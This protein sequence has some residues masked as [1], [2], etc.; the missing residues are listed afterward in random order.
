MSKNI[1]DSLSKLD[2]ANDNH[3]TQD[4]LPR[5]DTIKILSGDPSLTR[6]QVTAAAPDFNCTSNLAKDSS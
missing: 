4:G 5:L 2:P 3:W 1:T 6:E